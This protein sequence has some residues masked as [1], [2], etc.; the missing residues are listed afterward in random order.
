[1][2]IHRGLKLKKV[3]KAVLRGG[4]QAPPE[5]EEEIAREQALEDYIIRVSAYVIPEIT[6]GNVAWD[7]VG[8]LQL[9]VE[10][11]ED[12]SEVSDAYAEFDESTG[13]YLPQ[14]SIPERL[15]PGL[16]QLAE[17]AKAELILW[18]IQQL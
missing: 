1:M 12:A 4:K 15:R 7:V 8:E 5:V 6:T 16:R 17:R 3:L 13:D 10:V 2:D 18:C 9:P 11:E 14:Q